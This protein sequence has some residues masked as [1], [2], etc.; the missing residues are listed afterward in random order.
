MAGEFEELPRLLDD[1]AL[2][3]RARDRHTTASAEL[4][5][6]LVAENAQGTQ[7]GVGVDAEH[8]GQ[9]LGGWQAIARDRLALRDGPSDLRR[10]LVV[11][12][13]TFGPVDLDIDHSAIHSSI[14]T[15]L[16]EQA[17]PRIKTAEPPPATVL[18]PEAKRRQRARYRRAGVVATLVACLIGL[19]VVLAVLSP[20][21]TAG[22]GEGSGAP[23]V[24]AARSTPVALVRPVLCLAG[25]ASSASTLRGPLPTSCPPPYAQTAA[26]L[27]ITPVAGRSSSNPVGY[28]SNPSQND[29]ALAGYATT[30]HD[31]PGSVV[32]L[33]TPGPGAGPRYLLGPASLKL[34]PSTVV[35]TR[36][37]RTDVGQWIVYLKL[38]PAAAATWDAVAAEAFHSMIAIDF[39]GSVLSA[40]LI[41][42]QQSRVLLLRRSDGHIGAA[43]VQRR[44]PFASALA[45]RS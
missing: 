1:R 28:T 37:V 18:I 25:P 29:P 35:S 33:A 9:V 38:T 26:D 44:P 30:T 43:D 40:P 19:L 8:G 22:T 27:G 45:R 11:E 31:T 23:A 32:L 4:E 3:R 5:Q 42:P 17:D 21:A 34:S 36:V 12:R 24:L 14:M 7:H 2:T 16:E 10:H 6:A 20:W 41:E 13:D 39:H 15:T